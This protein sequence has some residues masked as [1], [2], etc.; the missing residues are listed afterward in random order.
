MVKVMAIVNVTPDSFYEPSRVAS[1]ALSDRLPGLVSAGADIIDIGAV[2]MRPGAP[3]VPL[4]EEWRRLEPAL[5]AWPGGAALS[6]DTTSS[7][8]VRRT[9]AAV[10]RFIVNDISAGEDD[11][12]MLA[13]VAGLGLPYVA[14]HKRGN[15]TTMD[16]LTDYGDAGVVAAV[17]DYFDAFSRKASALGL[18]D[19][20]LDPGFGFAKTDEQN[21]ELLHALPEFKRFGRPVLVGLSHKRFTH[22]RTAACHLEAVL[23]GADILRMHI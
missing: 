14:M 15:P 18:N 9:F 20:I 6:V 22:G 7:E 12:A 10:G 11:P 5:E 23:R 4:E 21:H 17:L 1:Y 19:W 8:I 16:S 2:S 3:A 13:T